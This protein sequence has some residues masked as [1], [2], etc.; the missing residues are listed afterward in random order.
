MAIY[1]LQS[2]IQTRLGNKQKLTATLLTL[3][4]L[5]IVLV[6]TSMFI[7]ALASNL[8]VFK[9]QIASGALMIPSPDESIKDWPLIGPKLYDFLMSL[10]HNT[11]A[12]MREHQSQVAVAAK[13]VLGAIIG[14]GLGILQLLLSV[15]IAGDQQAYGRPWRN[16]CKTSFRYHPQCG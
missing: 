10:T 12:V 11:M 7:N 3:L 13:A 15:I 4:L 1:P 16:V 2:S 14:T 5:A 6:P 8:M 9:D